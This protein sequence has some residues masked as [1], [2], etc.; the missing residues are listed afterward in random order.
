MKNMHLIEPI[1]SVF[2][3][4]AA[5]ELERKNNEDKRKSVEMQL[6]QAHKMAAIGQL[7]GG[8]AHDFNNTISAI[9]G[10]AHLLRSKLDPASPYQ[11]YIQHII[12]AGSRTADLVGQLAQFS[13]RGTANA[14]RVNTHEL[15]D[16]TIVFLERT[17]TSSISVE[18]QFNA[19]RPVTEGD[20]TLLQN[21]L[22]NLGINARDA[23]E[24]KGG[25]IVFATFD[26]VLEDG[27]ALCQSFNIEPGNYL[28]ICVS[29]TGSGMNSD[30]LSHVF[31]P[32]FT[33]KPKGKGTG[34]GL[35][36]VWGYIENFKGA[37]EVKSA[38]GKG[39]TFSLYL[40]MARSLVPKGCLL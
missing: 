6:A 24:E 30:V 2:A 38:E 29:D 19:K 23:M 8:I 13:H 17:I 28:L 37:I 39:A 7:A 35:A 20:G 26:A 34:L 22:L 21:V 14:Q 16:E 10:Y 15:M 12:G 25:E 1:V 18:K 11:K 3:S 9:S 5:A 31:E 27:N 33:T 32:F 4:R 40:P 36:N